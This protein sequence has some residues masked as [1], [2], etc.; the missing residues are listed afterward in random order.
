MSIELQTF[1]PQDFTR[2]IPWI[3]SSDESIQWAGTQFAFPLD[4]GQLEAYW[5]VSQ[6]VPAIRKIYKAVEPDTGRVV[7]HIELNNIDLHSRSGVVSRVLV[8]PAE[9]GKGIAGAMMQRICAIGFDELHLH[10]LSLNVYDFNLPAIACYK[11][12]GFVIEGLQREY[13]LSSKGYWN[14]YM[15][16]MLENEWQA[17]PRLST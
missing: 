2:L 1:A 7:G 12:A 10:R 8:N 11:R 3:A 5:R 17:R 15:M 14:C 4:E 6:Q 13:S 16:S 9:R